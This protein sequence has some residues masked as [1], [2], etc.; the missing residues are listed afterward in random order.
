MTD[1][2]ALESLVTGFTAGIDQSPCDGCDACGTRCTAGVPMAEWEFAAIEAELARL[3][4]EET[5]RVL[6]QEKRLPIPGTEESYLACRFRDTE[7]RRCLIY[8]ARPAV[9]R[10]FG[11]VEWLP[12]PIGQVPAPV[13]GAV[14]LMQRYADAPRRTYE[15]WATMGEGR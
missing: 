2:I 10:L 14:P 1:L 3:P 9:C 7:R 13:P 5:A 8:P 11:H 15:E 12:C 4:P 6:G